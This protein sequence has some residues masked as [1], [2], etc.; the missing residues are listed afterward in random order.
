M[1]LEFVYDKGEKYPLQKY[2]QKLVSQLQYMVGEVFPDFSTIL[3]MGKTGE[4]TLPYD[5]TGE[6]FYFFRNIST[7]LSVELH[8]TI[9]Q[10]LDFPTGDA[11]YYTEDNTIGIQLTIPEFYDFQDVSLVL[12]E[13]LAHEM[14]HFIQDIAGYPLPGKFKGKKI[15]YYLQPHEIEAQFFGFSIASRKFGVS[16]KVLFFNWVKNSKSMKGVSSLDISILE[17]TIFEDYMTY[18]LFF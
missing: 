18:D 8:L 13:L 17:T 6:D 2:R 7:P 15:D 5:A 11:E 9:N 12:T 14:T 3:S 10:G 16:I 4:I 1:V